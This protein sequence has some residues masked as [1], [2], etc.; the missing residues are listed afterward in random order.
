MLWTHLNNLQFPLNGVLTIFH[1]LYQ[2]YGQMIHINTD[3]L[4]QH[5]ESPRKYTIHTDK[6]PIYSIPLRY[7]YPQSS[8]QMDHMDAL[9]FIRSS[10]IWTSKYV[11]D[12]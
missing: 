5:S 1:L 10:C 8:Q 6:R 9:C 2:H 4:S 3:P 7:Q 11:L 12:R